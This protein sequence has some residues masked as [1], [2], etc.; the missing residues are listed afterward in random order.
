MAGNCKIC[1][2]EKRGMNK[3]TD[4]QII[5]PTL[6]TQNSNQISR[7]S[8]KSYNLILITDAKQ[9]GQICIFKLRAGSFY[10]YLFQLVCRSVCLWKKMSKIVQYQDYVLQ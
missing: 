8:A 7:I 1:I 5:P 9:V 2:V 10:S 4:A 3:Q 6:T